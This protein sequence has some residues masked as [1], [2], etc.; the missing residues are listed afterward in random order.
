MLSKEI[1]MQIEMIT[2]D[3]CMR[4]LTEQ[5]KSYVVKL[6]SIL[7]KKKYTTGDLAFIEASKIKTPEVFHWCLKMSKKTR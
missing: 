6:T 4:S 3:W 2:D 5:Q 7:A 1:E